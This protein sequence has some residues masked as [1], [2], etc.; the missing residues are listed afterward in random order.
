MAGTVQTP[1][2]F[3]A[4]VRDFI[5]EQLMREPFCTVG[6]LSEQLSSL[7]EQLRAL[8]EKS[9]CVSVS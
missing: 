8:E 9:V 6:A 5:K 1:A 2:L 7:Q 4:A 3:E